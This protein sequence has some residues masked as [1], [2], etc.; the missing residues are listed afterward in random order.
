MPETPSYRRTFARLLG[1]LR[2]YKLS[3]VVSTVLAA[4]SQA[5]QVAI[6]FLTGTAV[7][8]VVGRHDRRG[9]ELIVAAVVV[10]GLAKA[11]FMVGRRLL[12]GRQAPGVEFDLRHAL[13]A[14]RGRLSF[15]CYDRHP[16]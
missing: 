8:R 10:I 13:H 9:L 12:S 4:A 14:R 1:F 11:L 3:L 2:P 15:A 6:A 7:G 5:A 16:P